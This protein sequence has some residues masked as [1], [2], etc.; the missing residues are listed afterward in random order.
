M[1]TLLSSRK[2]LFVHSH[3]VAQRMAD[4]SKSVISHCPQEKTFSPKK[5]NEKYICEKQPAKVIV[6]FFIGEDHQHFCLGMMTALKPLHKDSWKTVYGNIKAP[7]SGDDD[8]NDGISQQS[9]QIINQELAR[10]TQSWGKLEKPR[11]WLP[12][13]TELLV[14]TFHFQ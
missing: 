1:R 4:C 12:S 6:V 11:R 14:F 5:K 9:H 8:Y 13:T 2:P 3:W 10:H 7:V